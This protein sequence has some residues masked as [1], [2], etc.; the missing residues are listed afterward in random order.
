MEPASIRH[1]GERSDDAIRRRSAASKLDC[2]AAL[3]ATAGAV[4]GGPR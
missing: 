1:C 4:G 2:F 3:A